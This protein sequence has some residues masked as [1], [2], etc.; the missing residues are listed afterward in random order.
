MVARSISAVP[1]RGAW[2]CPTGEQHEF[3]GR[4]EDFLAKYMEGRAEP[5]SA[6]EDW[7]GFME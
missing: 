2:I 4:T 1:G 5:P 6:E 7:S 3:L